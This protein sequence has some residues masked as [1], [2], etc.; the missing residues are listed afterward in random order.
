MS[1]KAAPVEFVVDLVKWYFVKL[2]NLTDRSKRVILFANS[3]SRAGN[4]KDH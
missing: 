3:G 2:K 1:S 4:L